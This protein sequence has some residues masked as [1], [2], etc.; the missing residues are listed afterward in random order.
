MQLKPNITDLIARAGMG[1]GEFAELAGVDRTIFYR[2]GRP[3]RAKTAWLIAN[4][5]A[6]KTG[7]T[8]EQA[9]AQ[10]ITQ[11]SEK[12]ATRSEP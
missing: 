5:Y 10:L 11:D 6:G 9:Y 12:A 3:L 8:P 4:A 2:V 7:I 1:V